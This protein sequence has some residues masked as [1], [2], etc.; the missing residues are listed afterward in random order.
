MQDPEEIYFAEEDKA[1][2]RSLLLESLANSIHQTRP[3]VVECVRKITGADYPEKLPNFLQQISTWLD[4]SLPPNQLYAATLA[5]RALCKNYEYKSPERRMPLNEVMAATFPRLAVIMEATITS[6]AG[7]ASAAEMQKAMIKTLYSCIHQSVPLYMQNNEVFMQWMSLV[8]R[9]IE[10]PVPAEVAG[11]AGQDTSSHEKSVFWKCKRWAAQ[12]MH[13]IEQRYGNPKVA[14]KNFKDRPGEVALA[15]V[16]HDQLASRFLQLFMNT[17]STKVQGA[18][19]PD[20]FIV[21]SLKYIIISVS[22]AITWRDLQPNAMALVCHVLFPM[23]CFNETDQEVWED[24]PQEFIRKNYDSMEDYTSPRA[25]SCDLIRAMCDKSNSNVMMPI[26]EFC[27][28]QINAYHAGTGSASAKDGAMYVIGELRDQLEHKKNRDK[29]KPQLMW[30]LQQHVFSD[31]KS[32]AGHLRGRASWVLSQFVFSI[33]D[34]AQFFATVVTSVMEL[35]RDADLPVK[36]QAAV[37][38][39]KLIYDERKQCAREGVKEQVGAVLPNVLQELFN[40]MESL[41]SDELVSTMEVLIESYADQMGP[42]AQGLCER[43]SQHFIKLASNEEA[44]EESVLAA[45]QCCSAITTLLESIKKTPEIY[46]LLEPSL[47]PVLN[48]VFSPSQPGGDYMYMEFMEDCLEILTY[49][50]YY[51]PTISQGLWSLFPTLAQ[52]FFDWAVDYLQDINMPLDNYISRGTEGFLANPQYVETVYKMIEYVFTIED[53]TERD[54]IEGCKLADSL[55]M[56]CVGRVDNAVERIIVLVVERFQKTVKKDNLRSELLKTLADCLYY[57]PQATLSVL[58]SKQATSTVFQIF[59][60]AIMATG[61]KKEDASGEEIVHKTHLKK[62]HDK[63]VSILGL[64]AVLRV[65]AAQMPPTVSSGISHV[66]AAL[67]TLLVDI[68]EAKKI[69]AAREQE[70]EGQG[71]EEDDDG[72]VRFHVPSHPFS[73]P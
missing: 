57:N 6:P 34:E 22:L 15:H 54:C 45:C 28:G 39:R 65:P 33:Q 69:R 42:Y 31:L 25:A 72:G 61:P 10:K 51:A 46:H 49:L 68:E 48:T 5:L 41:G 73:P 52:S 17:L 63:K 7:D 18:F 50:T 4:P 3:Q 13:R 35:L 71:E 8:Y 24:D 11:G 40:M 38:M 21:E 58:E 43:L 12:I 60:N 14:E 56:N 20:R 64:S 37:S 9:I 19:L 36:F 23:M 62:V 27:A 30:L 16:F 32:S 70:E 67:T 44:D 66:V 55:I 47:I 1:S 29:F 2:V 26:L 59:F 53:G